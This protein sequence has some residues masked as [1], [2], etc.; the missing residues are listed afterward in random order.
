[1]LNGNNFHWSVHGCNGG[2]DDDD[3]NA[4]GPFSLIL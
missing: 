3:I 4:V 1:M 2:D